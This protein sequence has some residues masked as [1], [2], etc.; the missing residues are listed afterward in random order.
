MRALST[1]VQ[2]SGLKEHFPVSLTWFWRL[3]LSACFGGGHFLHV[4]TNL[5][6]AMEKEMLRGEMTRMV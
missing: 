2:Q 4:D 1:C 6:G 3:A 5:N